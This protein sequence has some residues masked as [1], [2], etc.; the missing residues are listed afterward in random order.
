MHASQTPRL[1][2]MQWD[3]GRRSQKAHDDRR[4]NLRREVQGRP[5]AV[6]RTMFPEVSTLMKER[7]DGW[8]MKARIGKWWLWSRR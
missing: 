6:Q 5:V 1:Q 8:T 2:L 3:V 7:F 4:S